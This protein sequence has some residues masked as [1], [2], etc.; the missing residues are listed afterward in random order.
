[1]VALECCGT[2]TPLLPGAPVRKY[3]F[4]A[5]PGGVSMT[6]IPQLSAVALAAEYRRG[7]HSPLE[8]VS[9]LLGNIDAWEPKL[10]AM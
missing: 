6:G 2:V 7:E 10:N 3:I 4:G 5:G 9:S 1:M 8:V